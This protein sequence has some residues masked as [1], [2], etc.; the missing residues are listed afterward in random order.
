MPTLMPPPVSRGSQA[1]PSHPTDDPF[2]VEPWS[3]RAHFLMD[4]ARSESEVGAALEGVDERNWKSD[5]RAPDDQGASASKLTKTAALVAGLH[6]GEVRRGSK[7]LGK[8][9]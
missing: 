2:A 9:P 8:E 3:S 4:R 1:A 6:L 5:M 7:P